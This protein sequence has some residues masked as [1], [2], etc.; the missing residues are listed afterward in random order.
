MTSTTAELI[1]AVAGQT[2]TAYPP[3]WL[4]G[5]PSSI[6]VKVFEGG[7]SNDDTE[8]W[9]ASGSADSVSTTVSTASGA[10]QT[11]RNRVYLT[12]L[13]N[14]VVGRTYRLA[15]AAGQVELVTVKDIVSATSYVVLDADLAYDY[16][17]TTS[18][19]KG[20]LMSVAVDATWKSDEDN[21]LSAYEPNYR[22]QWAYTLNSLARVCWTYCRLVRQPWRSGVTVQDLRSYW[23]DVPYSEAPDKRGEALRAQIDAAENC[24]RADLLTAGLRPDSI[25]DGDIV[26]QLV[27]LKVFSILGASG[28]CPPN[29]DPNA[30]ATES[31]AAYQ[32]MFSS[33]CRANVSIPTDE[34]TEGN[35]S[36]Q[37]QRGRWFGDM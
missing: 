19:F 29:R 35:I 5:V 13:T 22:V 16:A 17:I 1:Y 10:S 26:R 25:R 33:V 18:T 14:V 31:E 4:D 11:Y 30:Y 27:M 34:G 2:L 8:E 15:N 32:R 12:A 37:R 24:V 9:T 20:L 28:T 36:A 23:P 7:D 3:E 6:T 21:V